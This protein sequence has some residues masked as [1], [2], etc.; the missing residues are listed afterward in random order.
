MINLRKSYGKISIGF[1]TF[2]Y[3]FSDI[4]Y[5]SEK[6]GGEEMLVGD[7]IY[8]DNFNLTADYAIYNCAEGKFWYQERPVFNSKTDRGKPKDKILDLE[9]KYI[10]VQ[11]NVIIIEAKKRGN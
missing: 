8:I 9:I 7:L 6:N 2:I 1:H 4:L 10:T 5:T 3:Y 11:N